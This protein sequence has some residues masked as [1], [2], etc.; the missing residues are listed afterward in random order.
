MSDDDYFTRI[1]VSIEKRSFVLLSNTGEITL[2]EFPHDPV[3][4]LET[5]AYLRNTLPDGVLYYN[6]P[7]EVEDGRG[8]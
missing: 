1:D 7:V 4:F 5:L 6:G 3:D 8:W 2:M